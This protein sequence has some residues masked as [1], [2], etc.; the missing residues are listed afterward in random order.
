MAKAQQKDIFSR[1]TGLGSEALNRLSDVP[2][3]TRLLELA[4]E[5]KGRLDEMQKKLRGLDELEKRVAKL[6]KQL[7]GQKPQASKPA[8]SKPAAARKPAPA[9]KPATATNPAPTS[10]ASAAKPSSARKTS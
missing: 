1:V 6:E 3:G 2:G 5:S 7:A 10:A 4:N 8:S 9:K